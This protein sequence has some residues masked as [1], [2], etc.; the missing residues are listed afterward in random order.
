MLLHRKSV[1]YH[2]SLATGLGHK[3]KHTGEN[4]QSIVQESYVC[5]NCKAFFIIS[6]SPDDKELTSSHFVG[7]RINYRECPKNRNTRNLTTWARRY[8][9]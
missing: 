3:L 4:K 7:A 8:M 6:A 2:L 9:L 1:K 5:S